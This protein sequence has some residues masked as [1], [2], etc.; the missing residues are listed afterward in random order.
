MK[1][2]VQY[3]RRLAMFDNLAEIHDSDII[4]H[5]L[6]DGEIMGD[7]NAS[8]TQPR[9]SLPNQMPEEADALGIPLVGRLKIA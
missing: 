8:K 6:N 7:E 3:L 1:R 9:L 2:G 4:T 5:M